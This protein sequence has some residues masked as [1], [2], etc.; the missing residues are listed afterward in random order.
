ML[1][2]LFYTS[3]IFAQL[4]DSNTSFYQKSWTEI[5]QLLQQ[6]LINKQ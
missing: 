1:V 2:Y 5:Y 6:E 4:A 3:D